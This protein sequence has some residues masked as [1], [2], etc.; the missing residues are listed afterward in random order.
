MIAR[1]QHLRRYPQVFLAMTGLRVA[2]FDRLAQDVLPRYAQ[3][4]T[5]R[6]QAIPLPRG[7]SR[8]RRR[9]IGAGH[10]F[11]LARRDHLLLTVIWL[12]L[13]PTNEVLAYLFGISDST[14]SRLLAR[15]LPLL[16]A[17]GQDTMRMPDP[18]RKHRRQLD[19]LLRDLPEWGVVIDS[20]E[21]PVQRPAGRHG[22][23]PS[24]GGAAAPADGAPGAAAPRRR[25]PIAG[26]R[27]RRNAIPSRV[28]S[29]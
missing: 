7:A 22:A 5:Q 13:Y 28:R 21:Q 26:I 20:F 16:A 6:H 12:R 8:A 11:T 15:L 1:Y 29:P 18:R 9:A 14:V 19:E 17:A 25:R 24:E 2:E 10:P 27:A 4:E 23:T 3:A